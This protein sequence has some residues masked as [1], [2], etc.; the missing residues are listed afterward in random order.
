[1]TNSPGKALE[2]SFGC[3][4]KNPIV[5]KLNEVINNSPP[6][7]E[8]LPTST[9][10]LTILQEFSSEEEASTYGSSFAFVDQVLISEFPL[11][12]CILSC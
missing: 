7:K 3:H 8:Y 10:G 6:E 12:S 9:C 5:M 2:Y 1:M 11:T 4:K